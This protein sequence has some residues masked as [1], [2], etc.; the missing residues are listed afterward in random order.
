MRNRIRPTHETRVK[1]SQREALKKA[2]VWVF[3]FI[4]VFSVAGGLIVFVVR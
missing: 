2:F 3:I 1:R 4:F